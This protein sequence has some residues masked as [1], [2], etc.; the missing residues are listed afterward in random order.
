MWVLR[1]KVKFPLFPWWYDSPASHRTATWTYFWSPQVSC[2]LHIRMQF[3]V[4]VVAV[5]IVCLS[6]CQPTAFLLYTGR[7]GRYSRYSSYLMLIQSCPQHDV[8]PIVSVGFGMNRIRGIV[9]IVIYSG[10]WFFHQPFLE[11]I[12]IC[13]VLSMR[14]VYQ[15]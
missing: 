12:W 6:T 8:K 9:A 11:H 7:D 14:Q 13:L 4:L 1:S 15:I 3:L 10:S 2:I 5:E